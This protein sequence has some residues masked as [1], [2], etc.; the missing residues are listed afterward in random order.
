MVAAVATLVASIGALYFNGQSSR[1]ATEQA[2]LTQID[3]ASE[4]FSRSVEQLGAE[5]IT[6]RIGAVYSF[7]RLMRDSDDDDQA[8]VEILSSFIRLQA[9]QTPLPRPS[10]ATTPADIDAALGVVAGH[11][12][13]LPRIDMSGFDLSGVD[14]SGA[15]LFGADL[16]RADLS[17]ATLV[18]AD[19]TGG[20][21]SGA[22]LSFVDLTGAKLQAAD[23]TDAILLGAN[24]SDTNLFV[25][26]NLASAALIDASL[27]GAR[28]LDGERFSGV[29]WRRIDLTGT[30]LEGSSLAGSSLNRATLRGA[31][32]T[33]ADLAAADLYGADLRDADLN[34]ANLRGAAMARSDL[35]GSNLDGA[36]LT[37][38]DLSDVVCDQSTVWPSSIASQPTCVPESS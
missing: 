15:D 27:A 11:S 4:R 13:A 5:S 8:I 3:Q 36:N 32:L 26:R 37:H 16:S 33:G 6:L 19:L 25:V 22:N 28:G 7:A 23:V 31:N 29:N 17:R 30:N 14:L 18:G 21:L 9:G 24:L 38:A 1:Q 35:T 10:P 34:G 12:P 2:R 20:H